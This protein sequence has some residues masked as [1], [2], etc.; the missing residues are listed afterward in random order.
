MNTLAVQLPS[1]RN[2]Y[3][4]LTH[5]SIFTHNKHTTEKRKKRLA[6]IF[7][8]HVEYIIFYLHV[9]KELSKQAT[10]FFCIWQIENNI[11]EN[12]TKV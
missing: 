11:F 4:S 1:L 8:S 7:I 6:R 10:T 9:V 2:I 3:Q 12:T 5:L